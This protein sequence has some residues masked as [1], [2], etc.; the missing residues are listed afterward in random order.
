ML[1]EHSWTLDV[2]QP[3]SRCT[4]CRPSQSF[5]LCNQPNENKSSVSRLRKPWA[6]KTIKVCS[7]TV[8]ATGREKHRWKNSSAGKHPLYTS[9]QNVDWQ[10]KLSRRQRF[11]LHWQ[12]QSTGLFGRFEQM[13]YTTFLC[14]P[15]TLLTTSSWLL[16]PNSP[17]RETTLAADVSL[18]KWYLL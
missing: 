16:D 2:C 17:R 14:M 7:H 8:F 5:R 9:F 12:T 4:V 11:A 13:K 18:R 6:N 15:A 10:E 3:R 1:I